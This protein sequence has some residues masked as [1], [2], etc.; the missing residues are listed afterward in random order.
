MVAKCSFV[1]QKWY[2]FKKCV[3]LGNKRTIFVT[4]GIVFGFEKYEKSLALNSAYRILIYFKNNYCLYI[5]AVVIY[6]NLIKIN[7]KFLVSALKQQVRKF[8][9]FYGHI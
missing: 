4:T 8:V 9:V 7:D 3:Y 1:Y 5:F 2:F 6:T